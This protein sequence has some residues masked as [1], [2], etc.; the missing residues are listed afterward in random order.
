LRTIAELVA[1]PVEQRLA[2][3]AMKSPG[4]RYLRAEA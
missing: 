3:R 2:R 1:E 4:T